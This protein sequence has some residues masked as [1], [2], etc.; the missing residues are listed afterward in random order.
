MKLGEIAKLIETEVHKESEGLEIHGFASIEEAENG[1]I[2]FLGNPKYLR[3]PKYLQALR[4]S[5]ASAVL[6]PLDFLESVPAVL[7]RV[8]NP[9]LSFGK[10]ID[11]FT[12][13]DRLYSPG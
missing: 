3:N 13:P 5:R 2:T 4:S 12:V 6:V 7:L 11:I 9:T 1:E 8:Q 10:I